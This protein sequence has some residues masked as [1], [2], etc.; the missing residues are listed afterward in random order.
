MN[1]SQTSDRRS[2]R[3]SE[4][5][6]RLSYDSS[7]SES[8]L[9]TRSGA[10]TDSSHSHFTIS[11]GDNDDDESHH[12]TQPIVKSEVIKTE[13]GL[14]EK[15]DDMKHHFKELMH[16]REMQLAMEADVERE[17][18]REFIDDT[19]PPLIATSSNDSE[20]PMDLNKSQL[21]D[22]SRST[23]DITSTPPLSSSAP[24]ATS[25]AASEVGR[26]ASA[27]V[28][29]KGETHGGAIG[30]AHDSES[31][32]GGGGVDTTKKDSPAEKPIS[33]KPDDQKKGKKVSFE[34]W[35]SWMK[36][37]QIYIDLQPP[38]RPHCQTAYRKKGTD[39]SKT[40]TV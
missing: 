18:D 34:I 16:K 31:L 12:I 30:D 35:D 10:F 29:V 39:E 33:E 23:T 32:V 28:M 17:S 26:S 27:S 11:D 6:L 9:S 7:P 4:L 25:L 22:S 21:D 24:S 15:N 2:N 37:I 36:S 5:P 19:P 38:S 3:K 40:I 14:E 8:S 20:C 1:P 13:P